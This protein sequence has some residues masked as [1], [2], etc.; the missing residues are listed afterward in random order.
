MTGLEVP[1]LL[2]IA[3][4]GTSAA[5]AG[6]AAYG[7]YQQGRSAQQQAKATAAW[8][9][10]NAK[11]AQRNAE[12]VRQ[13]QVMEE[14]RRKKA[15]EFEALQAE[16]RRNE[17]LAKQRAIIGAT[18]VTMEGSPLLVAEDT[19]EQLA[20]EKG[21]VIENINL[22]SM[23]KQEAMGR[24]IYGYKTTS[25][26]DMS[27]AS[28]SKAYGASAKRLGYYQAGASLLQGTGDVAWKGYQVMK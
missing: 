2:A 28:A 22:E 15:V 12:Y 3:A 24:E 25:I 27:R 20:L 18:G 13:Q 8:Q 5:G 26:L 10:Y 19:A 4:I 11:V 1:T 7:A 21:N 23:R 16:R 17:I 6:I 9:R 14:A